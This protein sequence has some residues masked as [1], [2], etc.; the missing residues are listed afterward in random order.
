KQMGRVISRLELRRDTGEGEKLVPREQ[1]AGKLAALVEAGFT[2]MKVG[3]A[4]L[5]RDDRRSF[6]GIHAR[7]E[8]L[9]RGKLVAGI[10]V[11]GRELQDGVDA[12]LGAGLVWLEEL[13]RRRGQVDRLMVFVPAGRG[14][15]IAARLTALRIPG[16]T[17]SLHEVDEKA[18]AIT[19]LAPFD[20]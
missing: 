16:A 19:P 13:R 3:R 1:F 14:D 18:S 2:S 5:R 9:D 11:S 8:L 20:Q 12:T 4:V 17:V 15:T 6:S 7:L 10:G